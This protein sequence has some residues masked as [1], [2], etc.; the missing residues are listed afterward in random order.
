MFEMKVIYILGFIC[1]RALLLTVSGSSRY[2]S[3]K[4]ATTDKRLGTG[5]CKCIRYVYMSPSI[6]EGVSV[7]GFYLARQVDTPS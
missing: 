4:Q 2:M 1:F 3:Q 7:V 6:R 5:D